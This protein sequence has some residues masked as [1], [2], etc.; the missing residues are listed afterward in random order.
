MTVVTDKVSAKTYI[1]IAGLIDSINRKLYF[2][3]HISVEIKDDLSDEELQ[4]LLR[5]PGVV[6]VRDNVPFVSRPPKR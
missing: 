4:S 5:V 1:R 3:K 2:A 6:Y